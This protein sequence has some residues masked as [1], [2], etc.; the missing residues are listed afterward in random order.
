MIEAKGLTK[1][2]GNFPAIEN[3]SFEVKSGEVLGF[4]G[5]NG[6]GKTTSMRILTGFM[7]PTSGHAEIGGYDVV[8]KSRDAR[9]LIGYLPESVPLYTDMTIRSY[10]AFMGTLKDMPRAKLKSRIDDVIDHLSLQD[11]ADTYVGR[12]SKGYRQRVG[13]AQAILHEP[14]LLILD[15][16]T[17]GID[18]RQVVE[19][20]QI[21][22]GLGGTHTVLISSHVLPEVSMIADRVL[23]I[24]EGHVVAMDKMENLSNTLG[25][26]TRVSIEVRGPEKAIEKALLSVDGIQEVTIEEIKGDVVRLQVQGTAGRSVRED[27]AKIIVDGGWGLYEMN[28]FGLTLEEIFLRLTTSEQDP[29]G[30]DGEEESLSSQ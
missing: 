26:N 19:T 24:H 4:L 27:I 30:S 14:P 17:I 23:I 12:L 3:V 8:T 21:I 28:P 25:G 16:P 7:P 18:P 20:R 1:Y 13:I 5:P 11:Y 29:S 10:L 2:Y 9:R 15:E 22:K 6:S